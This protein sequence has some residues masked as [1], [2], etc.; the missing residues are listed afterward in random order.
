MVKWGPTCIHNYLYRWLLCQYFTHLMMG[1][2]RPKHVEKVCSNKICILLHH[3]GVLLNQYTLQHFPHVPPQHHFHT[4]DCNS[5]TVWS[6]LCWGTEIC[7]C[8]SDINR[9][10]MLVSDE[11]EAGVHVYIFIIIQRPH[12]RYL[13]WP[14]CGAVGRGTEFQ[15]ESSRVR[16][17]VAF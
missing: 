14:H 3:V 7:V 13:N 11:G 12:I 17:S 2:W 5:Q 4:Q 15:I 10:Y 16:I 8:K 1:A 9:F 6:D